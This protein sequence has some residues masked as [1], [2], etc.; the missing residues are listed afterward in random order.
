[1]YVGAG[2]MSKRSSS[3][4]LQVLGADL[5]PRFELGKVELLAEAGLPEAGA[6]V[7]HERASVVDM[8]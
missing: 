6:D 5:R 1:M 2:R 7:E 3:S 8:S 4:A